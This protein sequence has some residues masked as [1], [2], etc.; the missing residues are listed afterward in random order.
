MKLYQTIDGTLIGFYGERGGEVRAVLYRDIYEKQMV[1]KTRE[2]P[3]TVPG[4]FEVEETTVPGYWTEKIIQYPGHY[5]PETKTWEEYTVT[6]T[7]VIPGHY[8][9]QPVWIEPETVTRYYW[10]EAHPARGLE[11]AW[12]PYEVE[13]PGYFKEQKVWIEPYTEEYEETI[14][15]GE[16]TTYVWIPGYGVKKDVWIEPVT[17]EK[18]VWVPEKTT[19]ETEEYQELEDVW[20][21]REPV[22]EYV[23]PMEVQT[24]EVLELIE[25]PAERPDL[26]DSIVIRNTLTGEE[27]STTAT[28]IGLAQQIDDNEYVVP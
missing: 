10:R 5:E 3:I 6:R 21:G 17:T 12:I 26:E 8:D 15:A 9:I 16:K 22:Y 19:Y 28:Y 2:I 23:D 7:R 14:P 13:I 11:A 1:T 18:K 25:A 27:L 24:F 20:V 4:H